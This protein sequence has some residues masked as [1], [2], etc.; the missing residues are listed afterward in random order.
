MSAHG[1]DYCSSTWK[2]RGLDGT[3]W[4]KER[5]GFLP[6]D[7]MGL[8]MIW[9]MNS[10]LTMM[11]M[12]GAHWS[13]A[14]DQLWQLRQ[15]APPVESP[16]EQGMLTRMYAQ[17]REE[18]QVISLQFIGSQ[19][20]VSKC[21][22]KKRKQVDDGSAIAKAGYTALELDYFLL[23]TMVRAG[24]CRLPWEPELVSP[25]LTPIGQ[26][27]GCGTCGCVL[28]GGLFAFWSLFCPWTFILDTVV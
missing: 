13:T 16:G 25:S 1:S 12:L 18:E 21:R 22:R 15:P 24:D 10:V 6:T 28:L 17:V 4:Q 26:R 14:Q 23:K 2:P 19:Q 7:L 9:K 5:S 3:R 27:T 8:E 20:D 11:L